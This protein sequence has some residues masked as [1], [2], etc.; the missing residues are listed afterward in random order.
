[1]LKAVIFDLDGVLIK[2]NLD[3]RKIKEDVISYF[4]KNGLQ[5][6]LLNSASS[7]SSIRENVRTYFSKTGKDTSWIEEKLNEAEKI[8]VE[9]EI[10]AAA[11][12]EL[13]PNARTTLIALKSMGLRLAVFTYNN[14]RAAQMALRRHKLDNFFDVIIA[15]D[16]VTR[17]KPSS[18]HLDVV[19]SK[20][21][22][23]K[24]EAIVVGD[25]EMDI[26]PCK[27]LGVK[28]IAITTGIRTA[29]E[30]KS[31]NPDFLIDDLSDLPKIVT[32]CMMR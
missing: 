20:L 19:L 23:T 4:V 16:M 8:A 31:Y 14:S 5:N 25:T 11:V 27:E 2:F 9:H 32:A 30:L 28:V 24:N 10:K 12:T 1:L 15:R 26:K 6:G 22:I 7:F 18:M 13:L 17:P 3:S 29:D 21:G